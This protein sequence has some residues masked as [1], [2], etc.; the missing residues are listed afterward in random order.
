MIGTALTL[1]V[2]HLLEKTA[3]ELLYE[4][5]YRPTWLPIPLQALAD[6]LDT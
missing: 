5:R 1:L 2:A 3:Y 6:Q 4:L